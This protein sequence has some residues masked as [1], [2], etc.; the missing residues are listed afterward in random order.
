MDKLLMPFV[1]IYR[2]VHKVISLPAKLLNKTGDKVI[3][4]QDKTE[5]KKEEKENQALVQNNVNYMQSDVTQPTLDTPTP[6]ASEQPVANMDDDLSSIKAN[7]NTAELR[8]DRPKL[9]GYKYTILNDMGKKESSTVSC[10][11]IEEARSFL[12]QLGFNVLDVQERSKMDIDIN[13]GNK[14]KAGDL[15]FCLTQ[16]STYIKA[17][18]PLV[19]S[20]KILAKQATNKDLKKS[21]YQV[22]YELL[23]GENFSE[24]LLAQGNVFPKLLINMVKTAEMTGDLSSIL[25]DMAEYYTSMENTRKQMK[26]AMT[27]P[28]VVLTLAFAVL[29]F[30]L[31]YLVPQFSAMFEEQGASLPALTQTI[32]NI[33]GFIRSNY[34]ILIVGVLAFVITFMMLFK[35]VKSF[36]VFVQTVMMHVP[37]FGNIIVYNEIANFTKTFA[38][39][40]NHGVFITDSMD[41]LS[42]VTTNEIY[43]RIINKT[44]VNLGKGDTISSAFRGEWAI[45]VVAYEMIVTGES[46]GQLGAMMEKVASHFQMLHKS[47]IDQMK[48]LIEPLLIVFLAGV[49]GVILISII[50]PMFSIYS[51]VQ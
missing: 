39:L 5:L 28:L 38:S 29:I 17:G 50:Q 27:Y 12:N 26:S 44:L 37:V 42:K 49:V 43:I 6:V 31:T 32:L 51:V 21:F 13:I 15:S 41:I 10:E 8:K 7:L 48:S 34:I 9:I 3:E 11:S 22:V 24:A 33:S 30:M 1:Y 2:G 16:L 23:K 45:P 4:A 46:T 20:V 47:I 40:I 19:D 35:K 36:R 14:I 18:I 25:D